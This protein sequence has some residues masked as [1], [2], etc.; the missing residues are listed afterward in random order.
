MADFNN[1][2]TKAGLIQKCE[3]WTRH[4]DAGISGNAT[5][6]RVFTDRINAAFE[7]IMPI[8]LSY[9]DQIR[10]D[11]LNHTDAPIGRVNIVS[12]QADYKITTDDNSL[13]ILN[14]TNVRVLLSSSGTEYQDLER[15][16]LDDPRVT[17]AMSPNPS[18]TGVPTHFLEVG[19]RVYLYPEP[20]YSATSGLELFF[21]RQQS[22]FL[23]SDTT[24]EPGIPLPFHEMLA[25]YASLSWLRVNR[26]DD[27]SLLQEI[28]EEI[29]HQEKTLKNFID[30]R[31]PTRMR[32]TTRPISHR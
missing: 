3:F 15:M 8:L 32:M 30:L 25:L 7:R 5:L 27:R 23:N 24:K 9:N 29:A 1:T 12:G 31:H 11:D 17:D 28:K 4:E 21:G 16:T 20:N 6:L 22:Y 26:A 10:W 2:T 14:I 18:N 13:D 19:N